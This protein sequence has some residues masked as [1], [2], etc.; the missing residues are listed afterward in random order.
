M[1]ESIVA[2]LKSTDI[3]H[4]MVT[5]PWLWPLCETLHF[6]GL[7]LLIG[8]A[9]FF[10]LRLMGFM[11]RVPLAAAMQLR[12]WAALGIA[13]NLVTGTLFFVGAPNQY[14]DSPVWWG[15]LAFL[16]VAMINIAVF[17]TG[18]G[19]R[20]LTLAAGADTP[21]SCK[22]AGAVSLTSWLVV[23]ILGRMLPFIGEAF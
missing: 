16:V 14:I 15:K 11:R 9:G 2:W 7:A 10:D 4:A 20:L 17:E 19:R 18:Q 12:P 3:S 22:L 23:L 5:L 1:T 8:T 6:V 21:F 13:I